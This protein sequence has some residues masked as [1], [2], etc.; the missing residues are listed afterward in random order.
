MPIIDDL[1]PD[2]LSDPISVAVLECWMLWPLDEAKREGALRRRLALTT[3]ERQKTASREDLILALQFALTAPAQDELEEE[4]KRLLNYG[5]IIGSTIRNVI[6]LSSAGQKATIKDE[7]DAHLKSLKYSMSTDW[8]AV[9][10]AGKLPTSLSALV[11]QFW[12]AL[13]PG[14]HLWAAFMHLKFEKP[15]SRQFPANPDEIGL[16]LALSEQYLEAAAKVTMVNRL[17]LLDPREAL[18]LPQNVVK[19]LPPLSLLR[20]RPRG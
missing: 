18:R 19:M 12:P 4:G 16:F 20:L 15:K 10:P 8:T 13:K 17:P 6:G 11:N 2:T 1:S 5:V 7:F 14:A 3:W 9:W